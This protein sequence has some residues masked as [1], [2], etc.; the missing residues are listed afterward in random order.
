MTQWLATLSA[1]VIDF[2][3]HL[4]LEQAFVVVGAI[5]AAVTIITE[6]S[7]WSWGQFRIVGVPRWVFHFVV[8]VGILVIVVQI[9]GAIVSVLVGIHNMSLVIEG[10]CGGIVLLAVLYI[11]SEVMGRGTFDLVAF[12]GLL[13]P[14]YP[15]G[16]AYFLARHFV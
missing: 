16:G 13:G 9:S 6:I 5:W 12:L 8:G 14:L 15:L 10:L 4:P 1:R 11:L 7:N 2:I 3:Q